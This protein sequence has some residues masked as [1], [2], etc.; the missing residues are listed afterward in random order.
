MVESLGRAFDLYRRTSVT[1][2]AVALLIANAIP[3][4]GVVFFGWSLLTILVLYWIENGIVGFWN[5]PRLLLAQGSLIDRET[6]DQR[7]AAQDALPPAA[8]PERQDARNQLAM[9]ARLGRAGVPGIGRAGMAAF[10]LVHY[11]LFW[12]VHG[13]FV[14]ALPT[15]GGAFLA[16]GSGCIDGYPPVPDFPFAPGFL[17]GACPSPFGAVLWGSVTLAAVALF[18]SHGASFL[19]NYVWGGEYRTASPATQLFAV[20]GRVVVLHVTIIVGAFA[21]AL[22]GAPVAALVVLVVLKTAYDLRLHLREHQAA[23]ARLAVAA[24]PTAAPEPT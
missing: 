11:G 15:F 21:V 8:T 23:A 18:I 22:L 3:L 6:L 16:S 17:E 1:R 7:L 14:F 4:V 24:P 9:M 19:L 20:Y 13:I 10:F 5:I 12:F 2:S